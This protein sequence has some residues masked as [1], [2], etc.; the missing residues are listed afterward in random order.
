MNLASQPRSHGRVAELAVALPEIHR[1]FQSKVL[2]ANTFH[3]FERSGEYYLY[4]LVSG[5]FF[6]I[7][8]ETDKLLS[9]AASLDEA[10]FRSE[11]HALGWNFDSAV[12]A[13]ESLRRRGCFSWLPLD[14]G[15]QDEGIKV[16]ERHRPRRIQ[17][18]FAQMCNL[19]CLYCYEEANGSNA[20]KRLMTF[21][22][23]KESVDYLVHLSGPRKDLQV[24]F[25]GGEPLLNFDNMKRVVA[26]CKELEAV[27]N[28]HFTFETITNGTL[29]TPERASWLC[30]NKFLLMVSIDGYRDMNNSNRPSV[31]GKD[32]YDDILRNALYAQRVYSAAPHNLPV[33]VRANLTHEHHDMVRVVRFLEDQGFKTIGI[34]GIHDLPWSD[35]VLHACNEDDL[36]DIARDRKALLQS[37]LDKVQRNE[38]PSPYE[39]RLIREAVA[40]VSKTAFTRGLSCGV[41]RN[42]NIVD[43]DGKLYPCHRYG[44]MESYVLGNV[45]EK[46]LDPE[47]IGNYYRSVN[48]SASVKCQTCWARHVC[49]G[50][51]A[52]ES[53]H[54]SGSI[55]E[56]DE[57]T[58]RRIRSSIEESLLVR[59]QIK[60]KAPHLLPKKACGD[61]QCGGS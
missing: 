20:R 33:K 46:R 43:C 32:Y 9:L 53:S 14:R 6:A 61:C 19:K 58:C 15:Q 27:T 30:E 4:D 54:P 17:L 52:G 8:E 41:G 26:Y 56:P 31:N 59:E 57:R 40:E 2:N 39:A 24:T 50:P 16:L 21:E 35:G 34:A 25:F 7:T 11:I 49:G 36:D 42:T 10:A 13:I 12:D 37:G 47:R 29:L 1:S 38:R 18:L 5:Q 51:C 55:H 23:A 48:L 45:R 60:E 22:M 44:N 28:K 3:T